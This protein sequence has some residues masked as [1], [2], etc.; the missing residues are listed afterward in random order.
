MDSHDDGRI[1]SFEKAKDANSIEEFLITIDSAMAANVVFVFVV[2]NYN[3][4]KPIRSMK[5][6]SKLKKS[7]DRG[8]G[9]SINLVEQEELHE[10]TE[11][12]S[13]RLSTATSYL[14]YAD[15]CHSVLTIVGILRYVLK[16]VDESD[17][18]HLKLSLA[19]CKWTC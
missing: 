10:N 2:E 14:L 8:V 12:N 7:I 6:F 11:N 13:P 5:T 4:Y 18:P 19:Y 3:E 1:S 9:L 15:R 16:V 17:L